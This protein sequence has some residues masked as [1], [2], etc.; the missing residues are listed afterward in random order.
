MYDL[1]LRASEVSRL[2]VGDIDWDRGTVRVH[3]VK[4]A[5]IVALRVSPQTLAGL[6]EAA[7]GFGP[8]DRVLPWPAW[9]VKRLVRRAAKAAGL[10]TAPDS[11]GGQAFS[12]ILRRSRATH[13]LAA[14]VELRQVQ[15]I[16]RH[17]S[18]ETTMRYAG[19]LA[20]RDR[21]V[22]DLAAREA[23]KAMGR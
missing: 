7:R 3:G 2:R 21:E 8:T 1:A 12:H 9:A 22:D 13:L 14:G 11:E 4:D 15:R 6:R 5:P 10:S 20:S 17:T 19:R 23:E 16:L 18:W